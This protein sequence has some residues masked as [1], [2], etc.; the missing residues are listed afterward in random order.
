MTNWQVPPSLV[1]MPMHM[2]VADF[3]HMHWQHDSSGADSIMAAFTAL[4]HVLCHESSSQAGQ[5]WIRTY[6]LLLC[7]HVHASR[8]CQQCNVATAELCR[9]VQPLLILTIPVMSEDANCC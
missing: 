3:Q 6:S 8:A 7:A 2:R 5:A 1:H 9:C 4:R